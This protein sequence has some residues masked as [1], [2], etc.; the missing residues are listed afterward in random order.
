M[1]GGKKV[2]GWRGGVFFDLSQPFP[3]KGMAHPLA[4]R[5]LSSEQITH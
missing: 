4:H 1:G 3:K 2:R 5:L